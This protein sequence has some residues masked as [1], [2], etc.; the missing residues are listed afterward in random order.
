MK[1]LLNP[2]III[3]LL[4][5]CSNLFAD[6]GPYDFGDKKSVTLTKKA[7]DSLNNKNYKATIAYAKKCI[8]LY[9]T[10]AKSQQNRLQEIPSGD[11]SI[12]YWALNDVA[13]CYYL[14]GE[15][16]F[17]Q[18]KYTQAKSAYKKAIR[19][20]PFAQ[21]YDP[22]GFTVKVK[23]TCEKKLVILESF[24]PNN[25]TQNKISQQDP[26]NSQ[27]KKLDIR[28]KLKDFDSKK[29]N[30]RQKPTFDDLVNENK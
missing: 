25:N 13:T 24:D 7:W 21:Y 8:S 19:K 4:L 26:Q 15:A 6:I 30:L 16:Y 27:L 28:D 11:E 23:D 10:H 20:F 18:K 3:L 9:E 2:K 29:D 12:Q 17:N 14:M 1:I 5:L 22:R